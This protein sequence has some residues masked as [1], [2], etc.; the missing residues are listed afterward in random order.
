MPLRIA[1]KSPL[2]S[3][4]GSV[5][6]P[7]ALPI[8]LEQAFIMLMGLV[9]A[10]MASSAGTAVA[11]AVGLVNGITNVVISIFSALALGGTVSVS[12]Y[13]GAKDPDSA[14]RSAGQTLS[15]SVVVA[16]LVGF[17][18]SLLS[19]PIVEL[20]F[21]LS[22][23]SVRENARIY[24]AIT[25]TGYPFL[26]TSLAVAGIQRGSGDVRSPMFINIAMNLINVLAGRIFIFGVSLGGLTLARPM[27]AAGAALA[28]SIARVVGALIFVAVLWKR[29]GL[30]CPR[31]RQDFLPTRHILGFILSIAI[32]ASL[33]SVLFNGGKLITQ[34]F[35]AGLGEVA[36]TADYLAAMMSAFVQVPGSGLSLAV[37]PLVGN[38][39]GRGDRSGARAM[40]VACV[41]LSSV[42]AMLISIPGFFLSELFFRISTDKAQVIATGSLLLRLYLIASPLLWSAS[43][44]IPAGLRGAGDGRFTM[45]VSIGSMWSFRIGLGWLLSGPL[46]WGVP[47]I[48]VA[49]FVDWIVRSIF[50]ITRLL[51]DRWFR[52]L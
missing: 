49:M 52:K 38:A 44:T 34:V 21:G 1:L 6:L 39:L 51:S 2:L 5:V 16:V 35:L 37:T 11:S 14:R 15:L 8:I 31:M 13:R 30:T 50:F 9:N 29:G 20:L 22:S 10:G 24:L 36:M 4:I 45:L 28:I 17:L 25:A 43:F 41:A 32:P 12:R 18:M 27:G 19:R 26:A 46:R 47:G 3:T 48:W 23:A 7:F 33:E 40:V 42:I